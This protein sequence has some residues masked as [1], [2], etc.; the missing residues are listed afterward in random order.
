LKENRDSIKREL[1][2][3]SDEPVDPQAAGNQRMKIHYII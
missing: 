2:D 3:E 1:E